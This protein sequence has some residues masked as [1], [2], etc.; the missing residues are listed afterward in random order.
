MSERYLKKC[1]RDFSNYETKA[2]KEKYVVNA[3]E[4]PFNIIEEENI[5]NTIVNIVKD[6][7]FNRYPDPMTNE[8]REELANFL[9]IKKANIICGNGGD[10]IINL[11]IMTFIEPDDY[12]VVH[13][14][15]F[16]MYN[17]STTINN[18]K[19]IKVRDKDNYI[20]NTDKIIEKAN[21]NK[22]K[23]IFLCVPNNPTGYLMPK[24][25]IEKIINSTDSIIVLD[26]AYIEFSS[27]GQLNYL[28]NSRVIVIRTLSK[29]FG[30]AGLRI[31]Y[32]VGNEEVINCLNKVKPPYNVNGLTQKIATEV[33]KNREFILER[34]NFFKNERDRIIQELRKHE[35]LT[36]YDSNTNFVL[37]KVSPDKIDNILQNLENN[38]ILAKVYK[39]R[40]EL[41]NCIRISIS[42]TEVNNLIIKSFN[43]RSE[44]E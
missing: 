10:E 5:K 15:S 22:A 39:E 9:N 37:V 44:N 12:V 2:I 1:L 8:L 16:E 28:D 38:S 19:I 18:G 33:L 27:L 7:D 23:V 40:P 17:I 25:E 20:I 30:L 32:G 41:D 3:N 13:S 29:L 31:G 6:Y 14:P 11:I 24:E 21:K 34:I 43:C 42:N 36:V 4:S 35:Y 26:Q